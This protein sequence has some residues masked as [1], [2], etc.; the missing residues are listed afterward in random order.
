MY[1]VTSVVA[2]IESLAHEVNVFSERLAGALPK[3]K[4]V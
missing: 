2:V 1:H 3:D 4:V